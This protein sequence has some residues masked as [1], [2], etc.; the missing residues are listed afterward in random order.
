MNFFLYHETKFMTVTS[1]WTG[2]PICNTLPMR[3][4]RV[5]M[6]A[7]ITVYFPPGRT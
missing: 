3:L 7:F 6:N 2:K 5:I 1:A 4:K